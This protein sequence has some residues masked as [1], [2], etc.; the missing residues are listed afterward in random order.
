[1]KLTR[2][3]IDQGKSARGGWNRKQLALLGI[4]WPPPRGWPKKLE[5]KELSDEDAAKFL[6]L[7][8]KTKATT[9][10]LSP[11]RKKDPRLFPTRKAAN[12]A[13]HV[14][15]VRVRCTSPGCS[16]CHPTP[17]GHIRIDRRG[18]G[19]QKKPG[20]GWACECHWSS[21]M[22]GEFCPEHGTEG[23]ALEGE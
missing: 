4:P 12:R 8:G 17:P 10:V 16:V 7:T 3:F 19:K 6:E 13:G 11:H 9:R 14:G 15:S 5:G 18:S 22:H 1:M 20:Y 21:E 23:V 2:E